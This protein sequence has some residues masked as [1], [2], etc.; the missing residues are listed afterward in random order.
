MFYLELR[1]IKEANVK[2]KKKAY[3]LLNLISVALLII[4]IK[5]ILEVKKYKEESAI[6]F[7]NEWQALYQ[8]TDKV[9]RY[10]LTFDES[11]VDKYRLY[12]NQVCCHYSYISTNPYYFNSEVR[13]YLIN[14]YDMYF[15]VLSD[16]R[17][18][19]DKTISAL[20]DMNSDFKNL[21]LKII[22]DI[23]NSNWIFKKKSKKCD[24]LTNEMKEIRIKY[25]TILNSI[26]REGNM[27]E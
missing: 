16:S 4:S 19:Y 27:P 17:Y 3:K 21:C 23:D 11:N 7:K 12:V 15:T 18:N 22:D 6:L 20:K 2:Y 1:Y 25:E 8:M 10:F 13:N 9:E 5:S 24:D 14:T 26:I